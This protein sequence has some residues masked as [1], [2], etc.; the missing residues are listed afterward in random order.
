MIIKIRNVFFSGELVRAAIRL[1]ILRRSNGKKIKN[2][3]R[4]VTYIA[5]EPSAMLS[6]I[7]VLYDSG[8]V[9]PVRAVKLE[10]KKIK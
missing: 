6:L 1:S 4:I 10:M 7:D 2:P 9:F 5:G 3:W 8:D